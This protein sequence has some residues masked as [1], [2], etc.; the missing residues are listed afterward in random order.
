MQGL[1]MVVDD[2]FLREYVAVP[3]RIHCGKE[4]EMSKQ[5]QMI[6]MHKKVAKTLGVVVSA[7]LLCWLP[8]FCLYLIGEYALQLDSD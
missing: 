3:L 8:F 6:K 5:Q 1:M 7:F 2:N 4:T